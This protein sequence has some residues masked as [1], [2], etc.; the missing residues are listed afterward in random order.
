MHT[1][2][3]DTHTCTQTQIHINRHANTQKGVAADWGAFSK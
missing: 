2:N 3:I 1:D